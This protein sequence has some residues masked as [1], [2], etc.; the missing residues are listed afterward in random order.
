MSYCNTEEKCHLEYNQL[1][2]EFI[3][4]CKNSQKIGMEYER[5]PVYKSTGEVVPYDG[6]Y[7]ICEL[8]R[9]LAKVDNWDYI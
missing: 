3:L 4:G 9:E 5:I 8:L 7:G 2:E 6:E 1:L